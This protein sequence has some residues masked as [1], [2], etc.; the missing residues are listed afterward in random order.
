M[1]R[2]AVLGVGALLIMLGT[3]CG[4]PPTLTT[5]PAA[6]ETYD[7]RTLAAVL[8]SADALVTDFGDGWHEA[9]RWYTEGGATHWGTGC[10]SFDQLGDIFNHST[11]ETVVWALGDARL[12]QRTSDFTWYAAEFAD[13]VEQVPVDCPTVEIG[14]LGTVTVTAEGFGPSDDGDDNLGLAVDELRDRLV[15]DDPNGRVVI[16][17][18]D[19]YPYPSLETDGA[20]PEFEVGRR[21]WMV[22]ATRHNVVSQLVFS[23]ARR[24]VDATLVTLVAAQVDALLGAP[25]IGGPITRPEPVTTVPAGTASDVALWVDGQTCRND[26][27]IEHDGIIWNLAE[28]IPVLWQHRSP[29]RG[30]LEFGGDQAVFAAYAGPPPVPGETSTDVDAAAPP[31]ELDSFSVTLTTGAVPSVCIPWIEP[32]HPDDAAQVGRAGRLDC[33]DAPLVEDRFPDSG[34]SPED[35]AAAAY[36]QAVRVEL[37]GPLMWSAID[38]GGR[39]V[40]ALFL[41]D[42]DDADWQIFTCA[43]P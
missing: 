36:P 19:A 8:E 5:T 10:S 39:V 33:D 43:Q 11:P 27:R 13:T 26:G 22:V 41:G 21:A 30:D 35:L 37:D 7:D 28:P 31:I 16:I 3:G 14:S 6:S 20:T 1:K 24:E 23:P 18:M 9:D 29:I 38:G 25:I 17:E 42:A 40:A 32:V 12:Y 2:A 15:A 4:E 34:Q